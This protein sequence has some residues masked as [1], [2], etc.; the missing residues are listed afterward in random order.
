M[1]SSLHLY[2]C[3]FERAYRIMRKVRKGKLNVEELFTQHE[4]FVGVKGEP[5]FHFVVVIKVVSSQGSE[6]ELSRYYHLKF[7]MTVESKLRSLLVHLD[8]LLNPPSK[9]SQSFMCLIRPLPKASSIKLKDSHLQSELCIG[10][11]QVIEDKEM[12]VVDVSPAIERFADK[13]KGLIPPCEN[14]E[15]DIRHSI[16][17]GL[18]RT[19]DSCL[20][21]TLLKE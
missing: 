18:K 6:E 3:E 20:K 1:Q 15:K 21:Q 16:K 14:P 7:L 5:A 17:I 4:P 10:I 8:T 2:E 13:I 19:A 12:G 11:K 9:T